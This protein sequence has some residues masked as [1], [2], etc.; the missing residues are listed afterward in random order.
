MPRL[1]TASEFSTIMKRKAIASE[2]VSPDVVNRTGSDLDLLIGMFS[3]G[4]EAISR[5]QAHTYTYINLAGKRGMELD[6]WARD[7]YG[8]TAKR[9]G[10]TK[11]VGRVRLTRPT[12]AAGATTVHKDSVAFLAGYPRVKV[13]LTESVSFGSSELGPLY[14]SAISEDAGDAYNASEGSLTWERKPPDSTIVAY[15]D[16]QFAGGYDGDDDEAYI[17]FLMDFR[18]TTV[19]G[20]LVAIRAG[21]NAVDGVISATVDEV[22]EELYGSQLPY[23]V[24]KLFLADKNGN[25]NEEIASR[26]PDAIDEYAPAGVAVITEI[27]EQE[28]VDIEVNPTYT[29]V[30]RPTS[31]K[32]D[33]VRRAIMAYVNSRTRNQPIDKIGIAAAIISVSGVSIDPSDII[34][35]SGTLFPS[36]ENKTFR[37]NETRVIV[38]GQ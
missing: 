28:L 36:A 12:S 6:L 29:N 22:T 25:S 4:L 2:K 34:E 9:R 3:A 18:N 31:I 5:Q 17:K 20:T 24:V 7:N 38:N 11:S 26:F 16:E 15:I 23:G 10:R 35:P 1:I 13:R 21:A 30:G 37:T 32:K 27:G 33:L 19:R 8:E 14:A